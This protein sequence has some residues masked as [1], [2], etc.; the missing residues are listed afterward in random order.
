MLLLTFGIKVNLNPIPKRLAS[1]N[2]SHRFKAGLNYSQLD[3][4]PI[5]KLDELAT[6]VHWTLGQILDFSIKL[7]SHSTTINMN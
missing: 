3:S 2:A 4:H 7:P 1:E 5:S 6:V